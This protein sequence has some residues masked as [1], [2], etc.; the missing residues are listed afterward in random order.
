MI[1]KVFIKKLKKDYTD[2]SNERRQII[3]LAN[4]VL[5]DSKRIIFALHRGD[6]K[7]AEESF[8]EIEKILEKL[9]KKFG[10]KRVY[11]EGSYKAG[12]EEYVEA[13]M[14]Y[15]ILTGKKVD[16][17][18]GVEL[19]YESYLGGICDA[20]GELVR[21]AVNEAAQGNIKIAEEI[22]EIISD[23]LGELVEFDMTGYLR[24]K[25]DQARGNLRKI[26]QIN[27]EIK[28]RK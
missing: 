20:T 24:T 27:Y 2:S 12:V 11:Q 25:Y 28:I 26:E 7:K 15:N 14:F 23:V 17:I 21:R 9:D 19:T 22:K 3:S 18:Q 1:N 4:V 10:H 13:K 5:H 8:K 16:K 6:I